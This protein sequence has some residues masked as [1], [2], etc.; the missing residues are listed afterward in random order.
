MHLIAGLGNPGER[1]RLTR[2]NAGFMLADRLARRW[3]A[4]FQESPLRAHLAR[5]RVGEEE[6]VLVKPQ[7]YMNLSGDAVG[8]LMEGLKIE[9]PRLL[10]VY[11]DIDLPLGRIRL[12]RAGSSGGQKGMR[13]I[14]QALGTRDIPRLRIGILM[15]D[16][17]EDVPEYVLSNFTEKETEALQEVLERAEK[18]CQEWISGGIE[19]AMSLYN[20]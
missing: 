5:A 17:P 19:R 15:G 20:G 9:P 16:R 1:Y 11:D 18:A 14:V 4:V 13:S 8:P 2:H 3:D 7:T 12:R 6:V 10:V